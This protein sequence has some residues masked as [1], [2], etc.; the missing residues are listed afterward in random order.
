MLGQTDTDK[1]LPPGGYQNVREGWA[2]YDTILIGKGQADRGPGWFNTYTDFGSRQRHSFFNVRN[3]G[4]VGLAYNNLETKDQMPYVFHLYS[5]GISYSA[6]IGIPY[7]L[8]GTVT[9]AQYNGVSDALF[10]KELPAH[11]GLRLRVRQD[12]KLLHTCYLAPE[13]AGVYG[14]L[15]VNQP[16][17]AN[18]QS[19]TSATQGEP[20][21]GNRWRFP[22]PIAIPRGATYNVEIE[23]SEYGQ[24]MLEA[25]CGPG[26]YVFECEE[27]EPVI[28]G[29]CS[30]V[31]C[32]LMG[33]R[34]VQQRGELHY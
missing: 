1:N 20:L 2:L 5:I 25:I 34:E 14:N 15:V 7:P 22:T 12:E 3:Q 24:E 19:Y 9:E 31:R 26:S 10:I 29:A 11:V 13:G 8:Q 32:S 17:G 6:A 28:L 33:K 4:E 18:T 23:L 16:G 30:V 27:G 21:L